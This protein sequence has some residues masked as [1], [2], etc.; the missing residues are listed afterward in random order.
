MIASTGEVEAASKESS[1]RVRWAPE[2][3]L[4]RFNDFVFFRSELWRE[5][6]QTKRKEAEED[7]RVNHWTRSIE[8]SASV[9]RVSEIH[10][11]CRGVW[12]T[13]TGWFRLICLI[14]KSSQCKN[15]QGSGSSV[16]IFLKSRTLPIFN[17][18]IKLFS[19]RRVVW[20]MKCIERRIRLNKKMFWKNLCC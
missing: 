9:S 8:G 7:H 5:G 1:E 12:W 18:H 20:T 17:A 19:S 10:L 15:R 6:Q 13:S 3:F 4:F 14:E 11:A 16:Q 2:S